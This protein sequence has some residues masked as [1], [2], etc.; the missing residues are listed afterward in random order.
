MKLLSI[1]GG[2]AFVMFNKEL[3]HEVS[4]NGAIIFGQLCS[5]Y[6]SFGSKYMLTVKNG[7]EYFYLTSEVIEEETALT[8]RQQAK[9]IKDLEGAGYIESVIMGS[10][11]RKYF[12]VTDKIIQQFLPKEDLSSDKNA[13]LNESIEQENSESEPSSDFVSFHKSAIQAYTNEQSLPEQ[14]VQAYK[15]INKK[16][17]DKKNNLNFNCNFKEPL[18]K[19]KFKILLTTSCNEFYTR[20]SLGRYSKKQWNTLIEKFVNDT[21][22]SERYINVPEDKIK[23]F[24]YKCLEKIANHNEY[25]RSEEFADY[26][27]VMYELTNFNS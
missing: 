13:D 24:A 27:N 21:I 15:D 2:N 20:F 22:E 25:K 9:A 3:A 19:D 11:A 14:K 23:G 5:S 7:K 8:Y 10:P 6:E 16:E 26:E 17:Q 4:V 1:L 12:H 18:T